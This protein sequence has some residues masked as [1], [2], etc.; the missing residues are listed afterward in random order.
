MPEQPLT[1]ADLASGEIR[2]RL[3]YGGLG[4]RVGP[5]GFRIQSNL[6]AIRRQ[7]PGT[8]G[9]FAVVESDDFA[10][11]RVRIATPNLVRRW[12]RPQAQF[13]LGNVSP[14]LPLPAA[15]ALAMLEWGLNWCVSTQLHQYLV[16]HAAAVE[17]DGATYLFPGAPGSGKSTLVAGLMLSGWRFLTDELVL[18]DL[19]TGDV[20]PFPRPISL[21]N[22]SINVIRSHAPSA[23]FGQVISKTSK[24]SVAHLRPHAESVKRQ[25]EPGQ[26][27]GVIFPHFARSA[28][29]LERRPGHDTFAALI[30]QSFNYPTLGESAFAI[31]AGLVSRVSG[32]TLRYGSLADGIKLVDKLHAHRC[33]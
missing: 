16:I 19:K 20:L 14:F 25:H 30:E 5:I 12:V 22:E 23:H 15:H 7:L 13:Y 10:D 11:F 8:Y 28:A 33:D 18:L 31:L 32:Y 3:S 2:K 9:G 6:L 4:V 24:G 21:K 29:A 27:T 17:R 26:P 1:V